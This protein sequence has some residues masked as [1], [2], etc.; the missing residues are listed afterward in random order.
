MTT[1][2]QYDMTEAMNR[3]VAMEK[4]ALGV[5]AD[6]VTYWPHQQ[7]S[8]PYWWNRLTNMQVD[9]TISAEFDF[10]IWTVQ[11]GLVIGHVMSGYKGERAQD[12]Y[13]YIPKIL[14]YFD[15]HPDMT[16]TTT[17]LTP[18]RYLWLDAG[19]GLALTGIPGGFA[20]TDNSGSGATQHV[21]LF[22]FTMPLMRQ[23]F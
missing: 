19:Y 11:A 16:D 9:T 14:S 20:A 2:T 17:Y 7:E 5:T 8:F 12:A 15:Q 13:G 18:F 3:L 22:E 1:Q 6:A 23:K 21:L 4:E 10:D